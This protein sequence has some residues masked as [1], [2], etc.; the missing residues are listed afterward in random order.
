VRAYAAAGATVLI[1]ARDAGSGERLAAELR[2]AGRDSRFYPVDVCSEASVDA[3][4]SW[5]DQMF[6]GLDF[7]FNNAGV[8]E[9][10][11]LL[12]ADMASWRRVLDTN[13]TGVWLCTRRA[14]ALMASR[15][16][17]AIV[18]NAS[19][20]GLVGIAG[21]MAYCVSKHAVVGLTRAA[22]LELAASGVTVNA[23]CPGLIE[24]PL[25]AAML[26]D[27]VG[28]QQAA[29]MHPLGRHGSA[30]EVASAVIWLSSPGARFVTG[31]ALAI[32]GGYVAR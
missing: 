25:T 32:D 3:L 2:A 19:I 17:G 10:G 4:F 31:Q 11:T 14:A 5:I 9:P 23:V 30:E 29:D 1:A 13:V 24:T 8:V 21:A 15:Q 18:N 27:P 20:A 7:L 28:R 22:A 26:E 6:G 12:E 16:A